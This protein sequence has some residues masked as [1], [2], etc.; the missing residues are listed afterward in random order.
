MVNTADYNL[1]NH[2]RV[3][4]HGEPE[5]Y[6]QAFVQ[7]GFRRRF[8]ITSKGYLASVPPNMEL[9][10]MICILLGAK[11]PILLRKGPTDST[12]EFV[13]HAYVHGIMHGEGLGALYKKD[14]SEGNQVWGIEEF[15]LI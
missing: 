9:G 15:C 4:S 1:E 5:E 3:I 2:P 7:H 8:F 11:T 12:L 10:D 13:G 14:N 6:Y